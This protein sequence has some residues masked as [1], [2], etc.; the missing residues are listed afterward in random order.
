MLL[1]LADNTQ[2]SKKNPQEAIDRFKKAVR[3]KVAKRGNELRRAQIR[4][5]LHDL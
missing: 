2:V 5:G 3:Q 4:Y 1:E